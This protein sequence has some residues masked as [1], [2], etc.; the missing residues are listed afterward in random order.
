MGVIVVVRMIILGDSD[1]FEPT[2]ARSLRVE[3]GP[4]TT[5]VPTS[6]AAPPRRAGASPLRGRARRGATRRPGAR[7]RSRRLGHGCGPWRVRAWGLGLARWCYVFTFASFKA[8]FIR[9]LRGYLMY[10]AFTARG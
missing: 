3:A 10:L 9:E 2:V 8:G 4:V 6:F 5:S 7:V 1:G